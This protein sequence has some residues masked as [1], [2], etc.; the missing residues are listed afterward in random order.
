MS[1][2]KAATKAIA[3]RIVEQADQTHTQDTYYVAEI[4]YE[5]ALAALADPDDEMVERCAKAL[6]QSWYGFT[7]EAAVIEVMPDA[8]AVL[9]AVGGE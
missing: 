1:E 7:D 5:A 8:R 4:A 3:R 6:A 9:K 2:F